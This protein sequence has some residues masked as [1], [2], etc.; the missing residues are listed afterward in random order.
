MNNNALLSSR[1]NNKLTKSIVKQTNVISVI[2]FNELIYEIIWYI[3][4]FSPKNDNNNTLDIIY[5]TM[6]A[7]YEF[8][9][10]ISFYLSCKF[11]DKWYY[12]F[13]R[14]SHSLC[15]N[16]CNKLVKNDNAAKFSI[17]NDYRLFSVNKNDYNINDININDNYI[18]M[19]QQSDITVCNKQAD[20]EYIQKIC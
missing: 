8:N 6:T 14:Y 18:Y 7:I 3:R 12:M 20:C 5:E 16:R 1:I 13:C 11:N 10:L 2:I 9:I 19:N 15:L 4:W 17:S